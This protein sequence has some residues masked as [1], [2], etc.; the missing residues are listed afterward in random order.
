MRQHFRKILL[1][2]AAAAVALV[3]GAQISIM[4]NVVNERGETV[5]YVSIGF[6]ADSIGTISDA[7]GRFALIIPEDRRQDLLFSHVSYE[8]QAIP[9]SVYAQAEGGLTV[10]LTEKTVG[11]TEV[12][13]GRDPELRTIVG[14][15]VVPPASC[16][17]LS[18]KGSPTGN[19]W[20]FVFQSRRDYV[21]SDILLPVADCK[22]LKCT[23]SMNLYEVRNGQFVNILNKPLYQNVYQ[24][25][26]RRTLEFVPE[27]EILLKRRAHYFASI[28]FVDTYGEEGILYLPLQLRT[29]YLRVMP[30]GEKD[31]LPVGPVIILKGY[32][33]R[34]G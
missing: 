9:Y 5:E 4:G 20:G 29:S 26:G 30:E 32:E 11:L 8:R 28:S 2:C 3:A 12:V 15:G 24:S 17:G 10:V 25:D 27:E 31:K 18:V 33:A 6:A 23:L 13:I 1:L 14:K 16:V 7:E 21:V 19:E 22:L 34:E